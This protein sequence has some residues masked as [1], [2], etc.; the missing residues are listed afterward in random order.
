MKIIYEE[1]DV[2][3]KEIIAKMIKNSTGGVLGDTSVKK[4]LKR[5]K[6]AKAVSGVFMPSLDFCHS[7]KFDDDS[8]ELD[9][10]ICHNGY[11]CKWLHF[12]LID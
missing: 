5:L 4:A 10:S 2:V 12:M 3:R 7:I 9:F 8:E 1:Q 11:G 6:T